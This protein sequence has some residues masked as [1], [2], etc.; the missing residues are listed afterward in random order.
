MGGMRHLAA[1]AEESDDD[2]RDDEEDSAPAEA[3]S[4]ASSGDGSDGSD[5]SS[6]GMQRQKL[7][8]L[9]MQR[10]LLTLQM[11]R[12][13]LA[14]EC[15]EETDLATATA[16]ASVSVPRGRPRAL[17][18]SGATWRTK[19]DNETAA[20]E[21]AAN[22]ELNACRQARSRLESL[23]RGDTSPRGEDSSFSPPPRHH[24]TADDILADLRSPPE[25]AAD[26]DCGASSHSSSSGAGYFLGP[27]PT[28]GDPLEDS[29]VDSNDDDSDLGLDDIDIAGD[30]RLSLEARM[31]IRRLRLRGVLP[32]ELASSLDPD[33]DAL[34]D[35]GEEVSGARGA[36]LRRYM[37]LASSDERRRALTTAYGLESPERHDR[38]DSDR[39]DAGLSDS[40]DSALGDMDVDLEAL[41]R[42]RLRVRARLGLDM[43]SCGSSDSGGGSALEDEED[44]K[45]AASSA[46]SSS[47]DDCSDVEATAA[48]L[49]AAT[50]RAARSP[51]APLP[52]VATSSALCVNAETARNTQPLGR[53]QAGGSDRLCRLPQSPSMTSAAVSSAWAMAGLSTRMKGVELCE[54]GVDGEVIR[55]WLI[56]D[57]SGGLC[58]AQLLEKVAH[59]RFHASESRREVSKTWDLYSEQ[60]SL[61][62]GCLGA[63]VGGFAALGHGGGST[64]E[65]AACCLLGGDGTSA[66]QDAL[67][68][69]AAA[70]HAAGDGHGSA[71]LAGECLPVDAVNFE[72]RRHCLQKH[73]QREQGS[74]G[75]YVQ[76]HCQMELLRQALQGRRR[77]EPTAASEEDD[78]VHIREELSRTDDESA[79][80]AEALSEEAL[81][82]QNESLSRFLLGLA[83][84]KDVLENILE[85]LRENEA[86]AV[87]GVS[88]QC[89]DAELT[90][91]YKVAAIRLHPDKGGD[92]EL[93]RAMRAAYE[94]IL[95]ARGGK[96]GDKNNASTTTQ[97]Q[98]APSKAKEQPAPKAQAA[99]TSGPDEEQAGE[100]AAEAPKTEK[101][102]A[103]P[104]EDAA[105]PSEEAPDEAATKTSE[106]AEVKEEEEKTLPSEDTEEKKEDAEQ[107]Q[108]ASNKNEAN[109]EC[110][111]NAEAK[112]EVQMDDHIEAET[113]STSSEVAAETSAASEDGRS[114]RSQPQARP[115]PQQ[116]NV[117]ESCKED[118]DDARPESAAVKAVI[119]AIPVEA[120]SRQAEHALNAAEMCLKVAGLAEEASNSR[121][122][123]QCLR[124][125][126]QCG[127]HMLDSSHCVNEAV[128]SVAS[129]VVGTPADVMPLL[130]RVRG[131]ASKDVTSPVVA[132]TRELMRCT[133]VMSERG[134][135]VANLSDRLLI[136]SKAAVEILRLATD[137]FSLS[138]YAATSL[139]ESLRTVAECAREAAEAAVAAAFVVGDAQRRAQNLADMVSEKAGKDEEERKAREQAR[140][141]AEAG[142][143]DDEAKDEAGKAE[144]EEETPATRRATNRRLLRKLNDEVLTLQREMRGLVESSPQLLQEV[145]VGQ[146]EAIFSLVAELIQRRRREVSRAASLD[147]SSRFRSDRDRDASATSAA[148]GQAAAWLAALEAAHGTLRSAGDWERVARPDFEARLLRVA[149]LLD[150]TLLRRQLREDLLE[151]CLAIRPEGVTADAGRD[152]GSRIGDAILALC[153]YGDS[154]NAKDGG[155]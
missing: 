23:L 74:L 46:S 100:G 55:A 111:G 118:T 123:R 108:D 138:G 30:D 22:V 60:G 137:S 139:A 83:W 116:R 31:A 89:S 20:L 62:G 3:K 114:S 140:K 102:E 63:L 73:P 91:A 68:T 77:S 13:R 12:A 64:V 115:T 146:K 16:A 78:F 149:A 24:R 141:E 44:A 41:A 67:A 58:R 75:S 80:A 1:V 96:G 8:L 105:T 93:F 6:V 127:T 113:S 129:C 155:A 97:A 109:E 11:K 28:G 2:I 124:Q 126:L 38:S 131:T 61:L 103:T 10:E 132:A 59:G 69:A 82:A 107:Q 57:I 133:D 154:T 42:A 84:H 43:S 148:G 122:G 19:L 134:L 17:G 76:A 51:Q 5:M 27:R 34:E 86:Y 66:P 65:A 125:L 21:E 4:G 110:S 135:K 153:R 101:E 87:L 79:T 143:G 142:D 130:D 112:K 39:D 72:F 104:K 71:P 18:P 33:G 136:R 32:P 99:T 151:T 40:E 53:L 106:T 121:D 81:E 95:A 54:A 47:S 35:D 45:S 15:A 70:L 37:D 29:D 88:P 56:G 85:G 147:A 49:G 92:A 144:E 36:V 98:A 128:R 9:K 150:A 90:K 14:R 50:A 152:L 145:S 94:R 25:P 119:E 26:V 117:G 52:Q 48:L 120:V 7:K